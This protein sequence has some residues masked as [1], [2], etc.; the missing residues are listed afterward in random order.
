M[1][2]I[3]FESC[4]YSGHASKLHRKHVPLWILALYVK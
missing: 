2:L 1:F 3:Q 4:V